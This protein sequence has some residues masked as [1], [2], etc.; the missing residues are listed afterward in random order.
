MIDIALKLIELL[1]QLPLTNVFLIFEL[2]TASIDHFYLGQRP[3]LR[4]FSHQFEKS[5]GL[6]DW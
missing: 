2:L 6:S 5:V 1:L 4:R 3:G